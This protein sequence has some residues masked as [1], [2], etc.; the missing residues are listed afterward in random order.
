MIP[1]RGAS[2]YKRALTCHRLAGRGHDGCDAEGHAAVA[3]P[4]G[5][6]AIRAVG[7]GFAGRSMSAR[8]AWSPPTQFWFGPNDVTAT[9][10]GVSLAK[11][12]SPELPKQA[13]GDVAVTGV[14]LRVNVE[15][16]VSVFAGR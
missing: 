3:R 12:G 6:D 4:Y 13:P 8:N 11:T 2:T 16:S 9:V 15:P 1:S 7:I 14:A 5:D 10:D